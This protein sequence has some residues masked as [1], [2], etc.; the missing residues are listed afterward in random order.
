MVEKTPSAFVNIS[1]PNIFRHFPRLRSGAVTCILVSGFVTLAVPKA[2]AQAAPGAPPPATPNSSARAAKA[3]ASKTVA[4]KT[5]ASKTAASKATAS[6]IAAIKS[7]RISR[8]A[9]RRGW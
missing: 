6:K 1:L 3:N 5:V 7:F 8:S 4:S 9:I 2:I